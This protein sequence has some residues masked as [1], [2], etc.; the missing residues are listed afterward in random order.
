MLIQN[1]SISAPETAATKHAGY[2]TLS[3]LSIDHAIGKLYSSP[4]SLCRDGVGAYQ[5]MLCLYLYM[6]AA[7][8]WC[9]DECNHFMTE[10]EYIAIIGQI[11][12]LQEECCDFRIEGSS[13]VPGIT[14]IP[15]SGGGSG[16]VTL[17]ESFT[18]EFFVVDGQVGL[19]ELSAAQFAGKNVEVIR[20]FMPLP[21]IPTPDPDQYSFTK[22]KASTTVILS[23]GLV[24]GE[25]IKITTNPL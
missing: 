11:Q 24:K 18:M 2:L 1:P 25:Y 16:T 9:A 17:P 23:H 20:A 19:T 7:E 3:G 15:S 4:L 22:V 10:T 21:G 5:K 13:F 14:T 6:Y 12:N 8:A